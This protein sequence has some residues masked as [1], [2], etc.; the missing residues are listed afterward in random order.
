M[1]WRKHPKGP[2]T[3]VKVP[4]GCWYNDRQSGRYAV[5]GF[6][7]QFTPEV[8]AWLKENKIKYSSITPTAILGKVIMGGVHVDM[9]MADAALFKLMWWREVE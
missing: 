7:P 5:V 9:R 3:S 6:D 2:W 4:T 1:F 8:K